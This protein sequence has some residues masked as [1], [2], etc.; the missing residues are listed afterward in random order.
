MLAPVQTGTSG[1]TCSSWPSSNW[2]PRG[3][4]SA[5]FP[6]PTE[7]HSHILPI[8]EKC[9]SPSANCRGSLSISFVPQETPPLP[10]KVQG[11]WQVGAQPQEP[12]PRTTTK[13]E[14]REDSVATLTAPIS[15][16]WQ[17]NPCTH[18]SSTISPGVMK[19]HG[20][21]LPSAR[22]LIGG[23][24]QFRHCT[25]WKMPKPKLTSD[26]RLE[27]LL[28]CMYKST[29]LA[30]FLYA[31]KN[32]QKQTQAWKKT[33]A[34]LPK[35]FLELPRKQPKEFVL[36]SIGNSKQPLFSPSR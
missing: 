17:Q 18:G 9:C 36:K 13:Q 7:S 23:S 11:W 19:A 3:T 32:F 25:S 21:H 22:F 33:C 2:A 5:S 30:L 28:Q 12:T 1:R 24:T 6:K 10:R 14:R 15:S 4:S 8:P 26:S 35:H 20:K 27:P 31:I 29:L 16:R 34:Q